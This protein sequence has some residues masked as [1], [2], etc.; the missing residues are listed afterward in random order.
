MKEKS[1]K[2]YISYCKGRSE[3][4]EEWECFGF[5]EEP[6]KNLIIV[7]GISRIHERFVIALWALHTQQ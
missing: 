7:F 3:A 4:V 1:I 6:K 5:S 2:Y